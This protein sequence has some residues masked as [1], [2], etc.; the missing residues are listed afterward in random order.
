[1]RITIL[2]ILAISF[3]GEGLYAQGVR[4]KVVSESGDPLAYASVY[5]RNLGDGVPTNQNGEFEYALKPG[6]YDIL[7]QYIGYTSVLKTVEVQDR[8]VELNVELK[9]Q[10]FG[11][12]EVVVRS[13]QEDP[14]LTVMRK[15]ISKAK[16]H[17]LQ[18]Q[19]YSMQVYLKG[20]GKLTNAPFFLK[21]KLKEEGLNL[22]EAY[23]SESVSEVKFSQPDK[24]EERVISI[25]SSGDDNATSPA[26][27]IGTSFYNE[28]ING[29]ISPLSR[30]AFAYYKFTLMGSFMEDG[31]LINKVKVT[32]R[33]R[34]ENVFEGFIYIIEDLWAIHSLDLKTSIMGFQVNVNQ[35]YAP[36]KDQVWMPISHTY[37]FGGKI[38]GFAGEY[39]YLASIRDYDIKLNPD[40]EVEPEI[41][42]EKVQEVP[43]DIVRFDKKSSSLEKLEEGDKL[44]RKE[45]RKM[46]N[47]Y[48]KEALKQ[49]EDVE[50]VRERNYKVDSLASKRNENYWDSI[51]PVKLTADEIRGYKRDDSLA[52]VEKAKVDK[53]DTT[54]RKKVKKKFD[55]LS[56]I[57]G[58]SYSFGG[59]KSAGFDE[60]LFKT[61]FNTVE[62]WKFGVSGYLRYAK[63]DTLADSVTRRTVEYQVRP[64]F[65]YGFASKRPY[66]KTDIYRNVRA[67]SINSRL[68]IT[69]GRYIEQFNSDEPITE[70]VN[71]LYTLV[72][73]Q[74]F[75]KLYE[76]D[77]VQVYHSS[78]LSDKFSYE[79]SLK[80]ADRREL[81]NQSD[82]SFFYEETREFTPNRPDNLESS[83]T[84]FQNHQA[85]ILNAA[86]RWRPGVKYG[87]R[88]G[89]RYAIYDRAPEFN[90]GYT[91]GIPNFRGQ[92]TTDFDLLE[93]GV[94]HSFL[95]GV[96]GRLDFNV[97]AGTFLN[98]DRMYFMDYKHFGGN[99]TI[100]SNMGVASN[101]RFLDY[102]RFSTQTDFISSIVH[103][104]FRKFLFTQLPMLRYTGLRENIFLNYLKTANSP[105]YVE[106]GYSLDQLF[107]IFRLEVGAG[108]ENGRYSTSGVRIG[109]ASFININ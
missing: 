30:S 23:T 6:M 71:M 17:R 106:I 3:F 76:Q 60:N 61:G 73:R 13:G 51:R 8:W 1:M 34:G 102:Y 82:N 44:T 29:A 14:A 72:M 12:Q 109:V 66:L 33:S 80:W 47:Q 28:K 2:M 64:A 83:P 79:G 49:R 22:N 77:F 55:P 90:F 81:F 78:R 70:F 9:E 85:L 57:T 11:L 15:A 103:Y 95:F 99:R 93:A 4:G 43:E 48:E 35:I 107:R 10:V 88:N 104:Q 36:V 100:F 75:M 59:G 54:A 108:F 39:K 101:Y 18:V 27:Y 68:G 65:R 5:I 41:I 50:V 91:K 74:N 52:V 19:E 26:P 96:S 46:V 42:D 37:L 45:F 38:F 97:N 87:I 7:V 16:F 24:I 63:V 25:R 105:H 62:G 98:N 32:P 94:S 21:K 20:T 89:R 53:S 56:V 92:T 69:G 86:F 40:L 58:G 67:G 84:N 31:I